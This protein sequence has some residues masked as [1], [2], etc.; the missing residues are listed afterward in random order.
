MAICTTRQKKI[1]GGENL[2][3]VCGEVGFSL[4]LSGW[5]FERGNFGFQLAEL[6]REF[7]ITTLLLG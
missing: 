3:E 5:A 7:F 6:L 2:S 4:K 1:S